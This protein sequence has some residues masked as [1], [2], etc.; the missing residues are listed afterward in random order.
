MQSSRWADRNARAADAAQQNRNSADGD[1]AT[2]SKFAPS[3]STRC[4]IAWNSRYSTKTERPCRKESLLCAW[5]RRPA[6]YDLSLRIIEGNPLSRLNRRNRHA[7]RDGMAV[8]GLDVRI[9]HLPAAHA[10][11]PIAHVPA[12]RFIHAGVRTAFY[13]AAFLNHRTRTQLI[14]FHAHRSGVTFFKAAFAC[15][16]I[17]IEVERSAVRMVELFHVA[18]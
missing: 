13:S 17:F 1:W 14:R 18:C 4:A 7:E 2:A 11:H 5:P 16:P 6:C 3:A 15:D 9:G 10:F 8:P 12:G